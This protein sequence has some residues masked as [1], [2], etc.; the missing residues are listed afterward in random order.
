MS[1]RPNARLVLLAVSMLSA[2]PVAAC[3]GG[4]STSVESKPA[5][6][7]D[8]L[9][10]ISSRGD[11]PRRELRL[12][13][14]QGE[15]T[16]FSLTFEFA[17]NTKVDGRDAPGSEATMKV[18][19]SAAVEEALEDG[20]A[21]VGI[22]YEKVEMLSA[23][24]DAAAKKQMQDALDG[25]SGV[26]GTMTISDRGDAGDA[27]FDLTAITDVSLQS[28]VERLSDQLESLTVPF[29]A[30][31]IG[32]GATWSATRD[33][34][35]NGVKTAVER[36]YRLTKLTDTGYELEVDQTQTGTPGPIEVP[37]APSGTR[38]TL[39]SMR[40]T[41]SGTTT[42]AFDGI[43]P[44]GTMKSGGDLVVDVVERNVRKKLEQELEFFVEVS[45]G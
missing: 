10:D 8:D 5:A 19:G 38:A 28:Q 37:G 14:R 15:Q 42:G 34:T 21:R 25:V 33:V 27:E 32:Q 12:A 43:L 29:P 2:A 3:N 9:V 45:T 23:D 11:A 26:H 22:T 7:P 36:R 41:G 17:V 31:P 39:K 44:A 35:L 6:E 13:F 40:V 20:S 4:G 16:A 18:S 1:F 24:M 30:Q